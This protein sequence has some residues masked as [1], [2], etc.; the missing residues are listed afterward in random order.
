MDARIPVE[1]AVGIGPGGFAFFSSAGRRFHFILVDLILKKNGRQNPCLGKCLGVEGAVVYLPFRGAPMPV[2]MR[3]DFYQVELPGSFTGVFKDVCEKVSSLVGQARN[4]RV[5]DAFVRL[6]KIYFDNGLI[7][8]DLVRL[9]MDVVPVR[10]HIKGNLDPFDLADEEGVAEQTAFLFDPK[11][12]IVLLQRH[13]SGVGPSTFA[14]YFQDKGDVDDV[15]VMLPVMKGEILERLARYQEVRRIQAAVA[16]PLEPAR[17]AGTSSTAS[18]GSFFHVMDTL[19][20]P[21]MNFEFSVPRNSDGLSLAAAKDLVRS[22]FRLN[23]AGGGDAHAIKLVITGRN[24]DDDYEP[25]N[26]LKDKIV[27]E[28]PVDPD[29]KRRVRYA[30]RRTA[31]RDVW[32]RCQDDIKHYARSN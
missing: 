10:G 4:L 27:Y 14:R 22:I 1:A 16:K 32:G 29:R 23:Q 12:N 8:G 15:I 18:I 21:R 7:E 13:R 19:K 28:V 11:T 3:I 26:L 6:H 30:I 17:V 9:R 31:I 20:A 5:G 24:E 25:L 2:P